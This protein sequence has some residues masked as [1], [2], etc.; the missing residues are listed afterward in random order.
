MVNIAASPFDIVFSGTWP[1]LCFGG[2]PEEP[3]GSPHHVTRDS[4]G[5]YLNRTRTLTL[6]RVRLKKLKKLKKL[7]V[8]TQFTVSE[9]MSSYNVQKCD[10]V[11]FNIN[12][13]E[14]LSYEHLFS[15]LHSL[16]CARIPVH[17]TTL[18]SRS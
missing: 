14:S 5:S 15:Q 4:R 3:S 11:S 8:P 17:G 7:A 18:S 16:R 1:F 9:T 2:C 10:F 12:F 6:V 13:L